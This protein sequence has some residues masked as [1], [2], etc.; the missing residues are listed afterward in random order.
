MATDLS[1]DVTYIN[2]LVMLMESKSD[3][4]LQ[5]E[6]MKNG[7]LI[8]ALPY[9]PTPADVVK[10]QSY[11]A[12]MKA[13]RQILDE[14]KEKKQQKK[15][16]LD[17]W[18]NSQDEELR[19]CM[20]NLPCGSSANG[21]LVAAILEDEDG[22]TAQQIGGW[23]DELSQLDENT[24]DELLDGLVRERV[25][26][27][28]GDRFYLKNIVTEDLYPEYPLG[29][30][31]ERI[32]SFA[33]Q[34]LTPQKLLLTR[35]ICL[36]GAPM[37]SDDLLQELS[38]YKENEELMQ[39]VIDD[40]PRITRETFDI[41]KYSIDFDLES[42]ASQEV[43]DAH[44]L[45]LSGGDTSLYY[46]VRRLGR[47]SPLGARTY[48]ATRRERKLQKMTST[49]R[50]NEEIKTVIIGILKEH[51]KLTVPEVVELFNNDPN[52]TKPLSDQRAASLLQT[53]KGGHG[54][55]T[56][57]IGG[58]TYYRY[59]QV[60]D[61]EEELVEEQ[62]DAIWRVLSGTEMMTVNQLMKE[63]PELQGLSTGDV[64]HLVRVMKD[65]GELERLDL[66][67][68]IYF[69]IAQRV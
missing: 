45:G 31:A 11:L 28:E 1:K 51:E 8:N 47:R 55:E 56:E 15:D 49:Q 42:L 60:S 18:Q 14:R 32:L 39:M 38:F 40:E 59:A 67:G 7:R 68:K 53:M 23:C 63:T 48:A 36:N 34:S 17:R 20:L 24:L 22:L 64:A 21:Q 52:C 26:F 16:A 43:L 37:N 25:L 69:R 57:T 9:N 65:D 6:I 33:D 19:R 44:L 58:R 10:G 61:A 66:R 54:A 12:H 46:Y 5:D 27:Q 29:W 62:K 50:E 41:S 4:E 2:N 35:L 3:A 13:A 30:C